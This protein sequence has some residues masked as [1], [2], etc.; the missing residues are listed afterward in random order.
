MS[1]MTDDYFH[2]SR[3]RVFEYLSLVA[4]RLPETAEGL[5]LALLVTAI[6][7]AADRID[8]ARGSIVNRQIMEKERCRE[9]MVVLKISWAFFYT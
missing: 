3:N 6:W 5:S 4:T 9:V 2:G 1:P 8:Q 7:W